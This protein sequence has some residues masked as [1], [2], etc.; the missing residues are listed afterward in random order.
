LYAN[1]LDGTDEADN[2]EMLERFELLVVDIALAVQLLD[3]AGPLL[4]KCVGASER[5]VAAA[6]RK[7]VDVEADK[8]MRRT[9]ASLAGAD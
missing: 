2:V 4:A 8:I 7:A 6:Y 3:E 9:K 5:A 1:P